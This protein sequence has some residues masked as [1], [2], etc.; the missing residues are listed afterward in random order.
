MEK[1]LKKRV[2]LLK[3]DSV[4]QKTLL[5]D[6]WRY[7]NIQGMLSLNELNL[8]SQK[9]KGFDS[10]NEIDQIIDYQFNQN[11]TRGSRTT[12]HMRLDEAQNL[13]DEFNKFIKSER[14][15]IIESIYSLFWVPYRDDPK[16]A[17][18]EP[19]S[20]FEKTLMNLFNNMLETYIKFLSSISSHKLHQIFYEV[21]VPC[22][23]N[24]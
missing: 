22:L 6:D 2:D 20:D 24:Q 8:R 5:S 9:N 16:T 1:I 12:D 3:A 21:I 13:M 7:G 17:P 4:P 18:K 23:I 19:N 15:T 10:S 14:K 11:S